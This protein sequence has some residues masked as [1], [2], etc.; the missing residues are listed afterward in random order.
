MT[1]GGFGVWAASYSRGDEAEADIVGAEYAA[2]AGYDPRAA[3]FMHVDPG[4]E[5]VNPAFGTTPIYLEHK[6]GQLVI[7]PSWLMHEV[8]PYMGK[9]ERIVVAF[10]S[11][12]TR[13]NKRQAD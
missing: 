2:R 10:N 1:L 12:V 6:E 3:M 4:N 11:W 7:F 5:R 9:S 8:L 13:K